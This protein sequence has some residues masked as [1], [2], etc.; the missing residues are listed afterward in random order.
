MTDA[1]VNVVELT[2]DEWDA[3][4]KDMLGRMGITAQELKRRHDED[5]MTSNEF[6][7]WMFLSSSTLL[8]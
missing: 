2:Q 8:D 7:A 1:P 3:L 5:N 6:K 4:V